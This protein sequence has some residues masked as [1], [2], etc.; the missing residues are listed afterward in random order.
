MI[1]QISGCLISKQPPYLILNVNGIGYECETSMT[2]F[3]Q[4]PNTDQAITL[5]TH[6]YVREDAMRLYAFVH[7]TERDLFRAL[8][9]VTGIGTKVALA[10]LSNLSHQQ[11][12]SCVQA[13]EI[14]TLTNVPGIGKKTAERLLIDLRDR[15]K[16]WLENTAFQSPTP[17]STAASEAISA[18]VRLGYKA[19]QVEKTI[20]R[21]SEHYDQCED[22]IRH[23]L[24][25]GI[26]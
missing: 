16:P 5:H 1:G 12:L 4:L 11:L 10:I 14:A 17:T 24:K 25:E 9:K 22:L 3:Y 6:L 8:I 23:A 15:L 20:G 13:Q 19:S 21:L 7:Q 2:S 18:L 26:A